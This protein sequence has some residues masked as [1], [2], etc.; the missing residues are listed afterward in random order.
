MKTSY[1]PQTSPWLAMQGHVP[2]AQSLRVEL[3][4][5]VPPSTRHVAAGRARKP[6]LH[7]GLDSHQGRRPSQRVP[8]SRVGPAPAVPQTAALCTAWQWPQTA[9]EST[10]P[11][12]QAKVKWNEISP[13]A[14]S[15]ACH[16]TAVVMATATERSGLD[17]V[18][19][20]AGASGLYRQWGPLWG[21]G[22]RGAGHR[23][24]LQSVCQ[25]SRWTWIHWWERE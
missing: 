22:F 6:S 10:R 4:R 2:E 5:P 18:L 15:H 20:A 14:S 3:P 13:F 11:S 25:S 7:H 8:G 9:S 21:R 16:S 24:Q 12:P 17:P 19:G 1:V 23:Q